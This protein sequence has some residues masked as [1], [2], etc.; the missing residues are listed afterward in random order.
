MYCPPGSTAPKQVEPGWFTARVIPRGDAPSLSSSRL[1]LVESDGT[2]ASS[3]SQGGSIEVDLGV[4]SRA[5]IQFA[6]DTRL[7][8]RPVSPAGAPERASVVRLAS[9]SELLFPVSDEAARIALQRALRA[10]PAGPS[11]HASGSSAAARA[12]L[13]A[14]VAASSGAP[15]YLPGAPIYED[16]SGGYIAGGPQR[17][18]QDVSLSAAWVHEL[19]GDA[20]DTGSPALFA[21]PSGLGPVDINGDGTVAGTV[22]LEE[23]GWTAVMLSVAGTL[24]GT[25]VLSDSPAGVTHGNR[26]EDDRSRLLGSGQGTPTRLLALVGGPV[27]SEGP[28]RSVRVLAASALNDTSSIRTDALRCPPGYYCPGDGGL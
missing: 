2:G 28:G 5:A 4:V 8:Q 22:G 20:R 1:G 26:V 14:A 6:V 24:E 19:P 17:D 18:L 12:R 3:Q 11:Y 10:V 27:V 21:S 13:L 7:R 25:A 23:D 15:V 9:A 16:P